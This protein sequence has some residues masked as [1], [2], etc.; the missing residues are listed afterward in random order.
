MIPQWGSEGF[1][2][3]MW[4][5]WARNEEVMSIHHFMGWDEC[6]HVRWEY[7]ERTA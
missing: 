5:N 2:S 7:L 6:A 4:K 3:M 1:Q